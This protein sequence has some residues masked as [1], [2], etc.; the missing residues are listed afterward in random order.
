M[1]SW[2]RSC[3]LILLLYL[4]LSPVACYLNIHVHLIAF[5]WII[6]L[7]QSA[8]KSLIH[9]CC[10]VF[11][12][13]LCR[14]LFLFYSFLPAYH[15]YLP[16]LLPEAF[17]FCWIQMAQRLTI[18]VTT[19]K[20]KISLNQ[21]WWEKKNVYLMALLL[22]DTVIVT[23]LEDLDKLHMQL[24]LWGTLLLKMLNHLSH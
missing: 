11:G 5:K 20:V 7:Q 14:I 21:G 16:L 10:S 19:L 1:I 12:F 23:L 18:L 3:S 13:I 15:L 17:T 22:E 6:S 24:A 2:W 4:Q 9:I 8:F